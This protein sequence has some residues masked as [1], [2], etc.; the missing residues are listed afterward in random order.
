PGGRLLRHR[1]GQAAVRRHRQ[2][3]RQPRAGGPCRPGG[4]LCRHHERR[5]GGSPGRLGAPGRHC[6]RG[7]RC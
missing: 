3:L 5:L 6:R 4:Q 2:E 1:G 7:Y